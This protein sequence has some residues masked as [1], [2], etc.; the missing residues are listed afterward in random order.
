MSDPNPCPLPEPYGERYTALLDALLQ[1]PSRQV[2]VAT[3]MQGQALLQELHRD[4]ILTATWT[5]ANGR[6]WGE[7]AANR[8]AELQ[9]QQKQPR[10][11]L[12]GLFGVSS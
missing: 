4:N 2:L 9:A 6:L 10:A 12:G 1:A 7:M 5:V 8:L 3:F 11:T